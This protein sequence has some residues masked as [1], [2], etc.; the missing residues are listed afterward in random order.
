MRMLLDT[1]LSKSKAKRGWKKKDFQ[2]ERTKK[3]NL[4]EL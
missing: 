3:G 1:V 2:G 4:T